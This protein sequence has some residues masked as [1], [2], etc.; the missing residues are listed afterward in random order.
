MEEEK[1]VGLFMDWRVGGQIS[2]EEAEYLNMYLDLGL[3]EQIKGGLYEDEL[4]R[5]SHLTNE[6]IMERLSIH[7]GEMSL[8]TPSGVGLPFVEAGSLD[9][10]RDIR[11]GGKRRRLESILRDPRLESRDLSPSDSDMRPK[12]LDTGRM[13]IPRMRSIDGERTPE[14]SEPER[15]AETASEVRKQWQQEREHW[16]K[17]KGRSD[18]TAQEAADRAEYDQGA[19]QEEK[20]FLEWSLWQRDQEIA[21]REE[22]RLRV[23]PELYTPIPEQKVSTVDPRAQRPWDITQDQSHLAGFEA[24]PRDEALL[25]LISQMSTLTTTMTSWG[26]SVKKEGV[27][28][29]SSAP[30]HKMG[31]VKFKGKDDT[32]LTFIKNFETAFDYN[33]IP[34]KYKG[35]WLISLLEDKAQEAVKMIQ[36]DNPS[37]EKVKKTLELLYHKPKDKT[38]R[39]MELDN[40]SSADY[41]NVA[42]FAHELMVKAGEAYPGTP[43]D[44]LDTIVM[45][46][47]MRGLPPRLRNRFDSTRYKTTS[48]L[49]Q[50]IQQAEEL[51]KMT[52]PD[53]SIFTNSSGKKTKELMKPVAEPVVACAPVACVP[54]PDATVRAIAALESRLVESD[55]RREASDRRQEDNSRQITKEVD[56]LARNYNNRGNV[57]SNNQN[58]GKSAGGN[59][60]YNQNRNPGFDN[61]KGPSRDKYHIT[62]QETKEN[63]ERARRLKQNAGFTSYRG[64][65]ARGGRS[66]PYTYVGNKFDPNIWEAHRAEGRKR[67]EERE[68]QKPHNPTQEESSAKPPATPSNP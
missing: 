54:A 23:K 67:W 66:M 57:S 22:D 53:D 5:L 9:E 60:G 64:G 46:K 38:T 12:E 30:K 40:L 33:N 2:K 42:E 15:G 56:Q 3:G 37:Y 44:V 13:E 49:V 4:E 50:S 25:I 58:S 36:E 17:E 45:A 51:D 21:K 6:Q 41:D 1:A 55:R 52:G 8:K 16:E 14:M 18:I 31:F 43:E 68:A 19:W 27:P 48:E 61:R 11:E 32:F 62:L 28:S 65:G 29:N 39:M 34:I 63:V 35:A 7:S 10:T 59:S 24:N 26:E 20:K 47:L